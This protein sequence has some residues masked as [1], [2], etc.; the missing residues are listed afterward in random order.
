MKFAE[1]LSLLIEVFK[2]SYWLH[3]ELFLELNQASSTASRRK[4]RQ[5]LLVRLSPCMTLNGEDKTTGDNDVSVPWTQR[6]VS[7]ML[8]SYDL[9]NDSLGEENLLQ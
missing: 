7:K 4:T 6:M 3:F 9:I 8:I 5:Y 2:P 1:Y